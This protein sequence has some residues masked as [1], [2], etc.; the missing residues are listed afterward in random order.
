MT[1]FDGRSPDTVDTVLLK[2][3]AS[4][5]EASHADSRIKVF[6]AMSG[7]PFGNVPRCTRADVAAAAEANPAGG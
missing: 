3:L 1:A 5:V 2:E 6:N 7:R 4:R